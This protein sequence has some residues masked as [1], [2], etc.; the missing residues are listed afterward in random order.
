MLM[1]TDQQSTVDV[2]DEPTEHVRARAVS[3]AV[4]AVF[5]VVGILGFIPGVTSHF[6]GNRMA[7]SGLHSH[8]EL[9][10]IFRVSV[11]HNGVHL[12]L[13]G[14]GLICGFVSVWAWRYLIVAGLLYLVLGVYGFVIDLDTDRNFVPLNVADNWLHLGLA[15]GLVVLG[16][17]VRRPIRR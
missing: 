13:G 12:F 14:A 9:F 4:G 2:A 5:I 6:D 15:V 11:F 3:L 10:G 1:T 16:L 17:V 8:A 7:F